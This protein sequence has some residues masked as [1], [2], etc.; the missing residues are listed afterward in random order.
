MSL[1]TMMYI[2][3]FQVKYAR[4]LLGMNNSTPHVNEHPS[5]IASFGKVSAYH[6]CAGVESVDGHRICVLPWSRR[7]L[8]PRQHA[9]LQGDDKSHVHMVKTGFLRL[10]AVLSNGRRQIIGFR[11]AGD[12]VALE[13]GS[14]YRYS[15]QAVSATELH[16][17]PIAAFFEVASNDPRFLLRLYNMVCDNL[18]AA[19]DL[20]VTIAKRD[21]EESMAAF[22]LDI[23][24]RAPARKAKSD[25]VSLPMLRGDMA[26]YLGLTSETVS[27][28]FTNFKK[29]GYI[30][31]RGRHGIRLIN[32]AALREI[33]DRN[34]SEAG[35]Q[36]LQCLRAPQPAV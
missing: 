22:L 11:S 17:V 28:I 31:V 16:T 5:A 19:H 34:A 12:F 26:D 13:S 3:T 23:D 4:Q 29:R 30:E 10:Y 33:S 8:T 32:R 35:P 24:A 1:Q 27:R 6:A 7:K 18:T 36:A 14:T 21:A 20:V 15:A 9:F 25:F 2:K